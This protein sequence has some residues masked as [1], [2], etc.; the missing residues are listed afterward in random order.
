MLLAHQKGRPR[1]LAAPRYPHATHHQVQRRELEK[2]NYRE[3]HPP[4]LPPAPLWW[5]GEGELE[6]G[7]GEPHARPRS[8]LRRRGEAGGQIGWLGL[9]TGGW[10]ILMEGRGMKPRITVVTL[11]VDDLE[12][13]FVLA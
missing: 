13:S 4:G 1:A 7:V 9:S 3:P 5:G 8:R 11:G 12:R 10:R 2:V 6:L